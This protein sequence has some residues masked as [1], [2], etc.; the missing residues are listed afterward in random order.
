MR[1]NTPV[2]PFYDSLLAKVIAHDVDRAA[3]GG[4]LADALRSLRIEGVRHNVDLLLATVESAAVPAG[5]LH[6]GF[7]DEQ[8]L[9][10]QLAEVPSRVVAAVAAL[11]HLSPAAAANADPWHARGGWRQA[12]VAQPTVWTRAGR[13]HAAQVSAVAGEST[14][15][16]VE[17]AD[18]H[19]HVRRS[20]PD[21][22]L[23][24]D[25]ESVTIAG[26]ADFRVVDWHGRSYRL[27]RRRAVRVED[28]GVDRRGGGESGALTAPMPGR[29]VKVA[30]QVGE[31]VTRNQP[32]LV[33]EA[34]KMEHVV[35][36]PHAGSVAAIHVHEGDQVAAGTLLLTL[37]APEAV[38]LQ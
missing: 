26:D 6:T 32:L 12:R 35:E 11:D 34:M 30:V 7:L 18:Q 37:G 2:S 1:D 20:V 38:P 22:R 15:V 17:V 5:E 27:A 10:A 19:L 23:V 21:G 31:E 8:R 24:V 4:K 33:L 3:A 16:L 14:Q 25:G 36:A 29:I 28:V 13:E 9:V